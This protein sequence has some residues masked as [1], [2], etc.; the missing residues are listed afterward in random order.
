MV[1]PAPTRIG[2]TPEA[3]VRDAIVDMGAFTVPELASR[4]SVTPQTARRYIAEW[5]GDGKMR[6]TG[7]RFA[8]QKIY[9]YVP[10]KDPGEGF[11]VQQA[12]R[13]R[14]GERVDPY[15]A[16]LMRQPERTQPVAGTGKNQGYTEISAKPVR[17]AVK[18]AM[19]M[20]WDLVRKGDGHW[21][22]VKGD[23]KIGVAGTP[24][25]AYGA[26][27]IIKRAVRRVE[28]IRVA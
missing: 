22:L 13:A 6:E 10:P 5:I 7:K 14:L 23:A 28:G 26:A 3:L 8:G 25:N 12:Q 1:P 11:K 16:Q 18:W 24:S 15:I 9:E 2:K 4:L 17:D 19:G 21:D 27:D 20:G